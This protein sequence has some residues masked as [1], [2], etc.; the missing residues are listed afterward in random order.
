MRVDE[1]AAGNIN[2]FLSDLIIFYSAVDF[3]SLYGFFSYFY[4]RELKGQFVRTFSVPL[5]C[6]NGKKI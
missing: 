3:I 5:C 2:I 6:A 1:R 4:N